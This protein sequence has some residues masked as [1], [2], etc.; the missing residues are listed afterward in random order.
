M[1]LL[2]E[3]LEPHGE[4]RVGTD[5][6]MKEDDLVSGVP[7]WDAIL[8]TSREHVTERVIQAGK[9]LKI[10]AKFGVGVENIDI[11]AATRAGIPVTNCPGSN[12]IA[13]AEAALALMLASVRRIPAYMRALKEGAWREVLED[14]MELTGA[15]F[16]IVGIG[17]VGGE[18]AR[19][20]RGFEGRILAT[21]PYVAPE[22]IRA[23][24]AEPDSDSLTELPPPQSKRADEIHI[25][26]SILDVADVAVVLAALATFMP[27]AT[28]AILAAW[29]IGSRDLFAAVARFIFMENRQPRDVVDRNYY[30]TS[31][32]AEEGKSYAEMYREYDEIGF[33]VDSMEFFLDAHHDDV[34]FFG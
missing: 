3:L 19:L 30:V 27:W 15:T 11:P 12:K 32:R 17:N 23:R 34:A 16:G 10:V 14:S 18:I 31:G 22:E 4:V 5:E 33:F 24:G 13:V 7:E 6:Q 28:I 20:L 9:R 25:L 21:D 29:G 2:R 26:N 8:V 1:S